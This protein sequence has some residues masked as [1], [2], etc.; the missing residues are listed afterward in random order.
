M[1]TEFLKEGKPMIIILAIV[2]IPI[3]VISELLKKTK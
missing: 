2:A 3:V 1:R